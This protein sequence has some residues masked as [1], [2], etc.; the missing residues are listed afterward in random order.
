MA[1]KNADEGPTRQRRGYDPDARV[2]AAV[3]AKGLHECSA[4]VHLRGADFALYDA[5][6]ALTAHS[7]G[8]RLL[9]ASRETL[10]RMT[11]YSGRTI[12]FARIRLTE[13]GWLKPT[14]ANWKADQRR[15][16]KTG[17]F[18]TPQF[19]V[20]SHSEWMKAHPRKCVTEYLSSVHG[21]TEHAATEHGDTEHAE[22]AGTVYGR[23]TDTV[24]GQQ[25]PNVLKKGPR[26]KP[27]GNGADAP[28]AK[29]HFENH[30]HTAR[31]QEFLDTWTKL[32]REAYQTEPTVNWPR[33]MKRLEP[34]FAKNDDETVVAAASAYLS[35]RNDF[36]A[37]H[38]LGKFESQ[39][40]RY[41]ALGSGNHMGGLENEMT[42]EDIRPPGYTPPTRMN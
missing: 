40:D 1:N 21:Q 18:D 38:P 11:G 41:R 3:P 16:G 9:Y 32:Y 28:R 35:E 36:T 20:V 37:G 12:G 14:S 24:Y 5:A 31:I 33:E 25:V 4:R 6:Q 26:K 34:I 2:S 7:K 15:T 8:A 19:E 29:K 23:T 39:F 27:E 22:T 10:S 17:N 13:Q 30:K 42:V